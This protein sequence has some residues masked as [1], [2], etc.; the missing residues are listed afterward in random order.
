MQFQFEVAPPAAS[1]LPNQNQ[2]PTSAPDLTAL[3][4]QLIEVQREQ[5]GLLRS[6]VAVHDATP[7]W[8]AFL[9]R[10]NEEYP[11]VGGRCKTSVPMLE[12]AYIGLIADLTE[13]LHRADGDGLDNEFILNE[14]LDRYGMRIGQLGTLLSVIAPIA[15]AARTDEA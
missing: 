13:Q 10:W 6:L 9:A 3:L 15:E 12:K 11:E 8:R 7:R 2:M 4:G 5:V 14:F 1:S